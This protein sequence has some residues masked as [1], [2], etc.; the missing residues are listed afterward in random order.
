MLKQNGCLVNLMQTFCPRCVWQ[1]EDINKIFSD[2]TARFTQISACI[3]KIKICIR[4]GLKSI[5]TPLDSF[6]FHRKNDPISVCKNSQIAATLYAKLICQKVNNVYC[7]AKYIALQD[8]CHSNN[9]SDIFHVYTIIT[10]AIPEFSIWLCLK[11]FAVC[12][13]VE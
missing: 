13:G 11:G 9:I 12:C 10:E 1:T 4:P 6:V 5:F 2:A 3:D 8:Q 7:I